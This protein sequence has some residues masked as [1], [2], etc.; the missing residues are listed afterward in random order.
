MT[1][2]RPRSTCLLLARSSAFLTGASAAMHEI[3]IAAHASIDIIRGRNC[4][5][6]FIRYLSPLFMNMDGSIITGADCV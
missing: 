6:L 5:L 2:Y 4:I 1:K 3:E